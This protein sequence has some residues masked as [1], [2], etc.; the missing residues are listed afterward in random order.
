MAWLWCRVDREVRRGVALMMNNSKWPFCVICQPGPWT[1]H[2]DP[3]SLSPPAAREVLGQ[4]QATDWDNLA[5]ASAIHLRQAS[6]LS[7]VGPEPLLF[8]PMCPECICSRYALKPLLPLQ[9]SCHLAQVH[10]LDI[11]PKDNY[12]ISLKWNEANQIELSQTEWPSLRH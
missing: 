6:G 10:V 11:S 12:W 7:W 5:L 8:I 4:P 2:M 3:A 1:Y 9:L